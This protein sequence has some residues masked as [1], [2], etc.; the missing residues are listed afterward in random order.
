MK[1]VMFAVLIVALAF[2]FMLAGCGKKGPQESPTVTATETVITGGVTG[3]PKGETK[4][5]TSLKTGLGSVISI[6][7]SASVSEGADALAEADIVMA[8]V[9]LD[10][11]DKIVN[12]K[13]DM[14]QSKIS[15][16]T[17]GQLVTDINTA[18]KTKVELGNEYGMKKASSI[19]KEWFEQMAALEGWMVGKTIG[20]IMGMELSAGGTPAAADLTSS[21]TINVTDYL[22][23]VQK[24]VN[25]AKDFGI[26]ITGKTKTGFGNAVSLASSKSAANGTDAVGQTDNVMAAV[27]VDDKG[28]IVGVM[29]DSAQVKVTVNAQGKITTDL[30]AELKTKGELGD[31]YG[32]KKASGI[33]KEWYEQINELSRWI[34]GKTID[35]VMGM[36]TTDEGIPAE[37]DLT[38]SVTIHVND[39]LNTVQKAVQNAK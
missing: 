5:P 2:S 10:A 1:K 3:T 21:V 23:A 30:S 36:K 20:E 26:A 19:G 17:K 6:A 39:Y 31:E 11:S 9:T 16:N 32:M 14:L 24:A 22:R 34:I 33:G 28:V 35:E 13:I 25:N 4:M 15:F 18:P 27:T 8:A 37:A 7:K 29:I 38:S 12:V